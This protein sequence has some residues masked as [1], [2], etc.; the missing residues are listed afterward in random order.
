MKFPMKQRNNT[1]GNQELNTDGCPWRKKK[2]LWRRNLTE[3]KCWNP[4]V[5]CIPGRRE[6]CHSGRSTDG[7]EAPHATHPS[8]YSASL[9][10]PCFLQ[11]SEGPWSKTSGEGRGHCKRK[12]PRVNTGRETGVVT[13]STRKSSSISEWLICTCCPG[14]SI[15]LFRPPSQ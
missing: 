6:S 12:G 15:L 4:S 13:N 11:A 3:R 5:H 14:R 1:F 2:S 9:H 8:L 10:W 7:D